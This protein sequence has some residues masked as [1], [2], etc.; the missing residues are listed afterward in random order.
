MSPAAYTIPTGPMPAY[1]AGIIGGQTPPFVDPTVRAALGINPQAGQTLRGLYQAALLNSAVRQ[2]QIQSTPIPHPI[3]RGLAATLMGAG[4]GA[5]DAMRNISDYGRYRPNPAEESRPEQFFYQP[6]IAAEQNYLNTLKSLGEAAALEPRAA[7]EKLLALRPG[8][9]AFS[10]ARGPLYTVPEA[11]PLPKPIT[12][13][14]RVIPGTNFEINARTGETRQMTGVPGKQPAAITPYQQK[15]L[16]LREQQLGI[17]RQKAGKGGAANVSPVL[18]DK[19]DQDRQRALAVLEW[20]YAPLTGRNSESLAELAGIRGTAGN[21]KLP[22]GTTIEQVGTASDPKQRQTLL[23]QLQADKQAVESNYEA[24][25][26][27]L[28]VP[29]RTVRFTAAPSAAPRGGA[30]SISAWRRGNPN[31]NVTDQQLREA[32]E[33]R[34]LAV[35]P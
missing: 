28:G 7:A 19:M 12:E 35:I 13:D 23:Q 22:D 26:R 4:Q 5:F 17:E 8:E 18:L 27:N 15:E 21:F 16:N 6:Q 2:R 31:S 1:D 24:R 9:T 20:R 30:F 34:G 25:R 29:T 14:W 3:L 11:S 33:Q 10:T 32:A